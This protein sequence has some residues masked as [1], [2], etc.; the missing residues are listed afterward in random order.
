MKALVSTIEE[1]QELQKKVARRDNTILRLTNKLKKLESQH[2]RDKVEI[3]VLQSQLQPQLQLV[4]QLQQQV[5]QH[6]LKLQHQDHQIKICSQYA[7]TET[8]SP[9]LQSQL[10]CDLQPQFRPRP[11]KRDRIFATKSRK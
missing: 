6:H 7:R 10:P 11:K 4:D 5:Q 9:S 1:D 8:S 3:E 2:L